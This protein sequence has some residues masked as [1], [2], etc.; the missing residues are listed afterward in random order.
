MD[1]ISKLHLETLYTQECTLHGSIQFFWQ[2]IKWSDFLVLLSEQWVKMCVPENHMGN[3]SWPDIV[4][5]FAC[6]LE[7]SWSNALSNYIFPSDVIIGIFQ[8]LPSVLLMK[9]VSRTNKM[10]QIY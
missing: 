10:L 3:K 5:V 8:N 7:L 4:R 2:S 9:S 6:N 1:V